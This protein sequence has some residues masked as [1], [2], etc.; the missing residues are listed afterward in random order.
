[1]KLTR[2]TVNRQDSTAAK[3][4]SQVATDLGR[5]GSVTTVISHNE[6]MTGLEWGRGRLTLHGKLKRE[7][8]VLYCTA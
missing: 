3:V 8:I 2:M 1:M 5:G 7:T 6:T 4:W